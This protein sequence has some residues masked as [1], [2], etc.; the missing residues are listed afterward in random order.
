MKSFKL[1]LE[2]DSSIHYHNIFLHFKN[3]DDNLFEK[4]IYRKG[5]MFMGGDY[6]ERKKRENYH[7]ELHDRL[8]EHYD[9]DHYDEHQI[10]EINDYTGLDSVMM[11]KYLSGVEYHKGE[12]TPEFREYMKGELQ[13][14]VS[15]LDSAMKV[16]QT[17]HRLLT[18]TGI[19]RPPSERFKKEK[20]ESDGHWYAHAPA[21]SSLST[22]PKVA[23]MFAM[24]KGHEPD[25]VSEWRPRTTFHILKLTV[26]QGSHGVFAHDHITSTEGEHEFI[27]PRNSKMKI[28]HKPTV[29]VRKND[30]D[31]MAKQYHIWHAKLIH[32]GTKDVG[33]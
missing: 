33:E 11:N 6:D 5:H 2:S 12:K 22:N 19:K 29:I 21:Y 26:P 10:K 24:E 1:F 3:L 8:A 20:I 31:V 30:K 25:D 23:H 28:Y 32:D 27:L 13:K 16:R 14:S 15:V 7:K 9:K 17:P 18:Y 4:E